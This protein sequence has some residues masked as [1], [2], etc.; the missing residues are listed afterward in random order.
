MISHS[1]RD[2]STATVEEVVACEGSTLSVECDI[3]SVTVAATMFK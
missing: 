2:A 3:P 1:T